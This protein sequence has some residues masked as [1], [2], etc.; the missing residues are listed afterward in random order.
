MKKS[1]FHGDYITVPPDRFSYT[2]KRMRKLEQEAEEEMEEEY[3]SKVRELNSAIY[4]GMEF[5]WHGKKIFFFEMYKVSL[6]GL[7]FPKK[8]QKPHYG[9]IGLGDVVKYHSELQRAIKGKQ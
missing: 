1:K 4:E 9:M 7:R 5:L 8:G 3:G 2:D 6:N